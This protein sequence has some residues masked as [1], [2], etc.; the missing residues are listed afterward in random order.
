MKPMKPTFLAPCPQARA[1][2]EAQVRRV[3]VAFAEFERD[4]DGVLAGL[5]AL[6]AELAAPRAAALD[7]LPALDPGPDEVR[8]CD[9]QPCGGVCAKIG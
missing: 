9:V 1:E 6:E 8:Q 3:V 7:P 5:G 2:V 4:R